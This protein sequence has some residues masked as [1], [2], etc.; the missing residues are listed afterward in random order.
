MATVKIGTQNFEKLRESKAFYVD[1]TN[2]IRE[3]WESGDEVTL[4]TRP[5]R[6][7]KTLT[8]STVE[9]FFSYRYEKRSDLFE[10]L[11]IW[12]EDAYKKMQGTYPVI[13]LSFSNIKEDNF[14]A[15]REK[16]CRMIADLYDDYH[17]LL[18]SSLLTSNE[19][20]YIR[21]TIEKKDAVSD[22]FATMTLN[23]LSHYLSKHH[24]K[25]VIVLLDEY[26]TPMQEAYVNGYSKEL[27]GFLRGFFNVTFKD[28]PYMER[29]IMTGITRVS[30]ESVFSDL[31]NLKIVTTTSDEYAASFGFTEKEVFLALEDFGYEDRKQEVKKWYDGFVFGN[32][33]DIYNPWSIINFLDTGKIAA[34]WA[35]TS[36]NSLVGRL[37]QRGSY[38]V[39]II[40]EDLLQ[41]N[42][43]YT[44]LDEQIIFEQ[45]DKKETS[46]WSLLLAS[47]Y[48][49]AESCVFN[50]KRNRYCYGLKLTNLEVQVMFEEMIEEWFNHGF[51]L[52]LIVDLKDRY[53]V[54]SNRESG[55]GRYDVVLEPRNVEDDAI[56]LEFKVYDKEDGELSDTVSAAL[57]QIEKKQYAT[58]LMEKG[59]SKDKIKKYGF[60]FQ[61]KK[62]LIG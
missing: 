55:F 50:E 47:G 39:K 16:I 26:D 48:L 22:V 15:A 12:K 19:K 10:G 13:S 46:I 58:A 36:S 9:Q 49:K 23:R 62:V 41:G 51:V 33:A 57:A 3:W 44:E 52:G 35:N 54:T 40:M 42:I 56:T 11:S 4:I 59:I 43:V 28:N 1:K 7:G 27:T 21:E 5:R 53:I 29:A 32:Q 60:A 38:N 14:P 25:K 24:G 37:I 18:E 6:F 8:M 45:L 30:K 17:Y 20:N 34:Y 31:N 61:G 2:F